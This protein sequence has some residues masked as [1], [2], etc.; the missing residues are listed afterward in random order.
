MECKLEGFI[1]CS[2][3]LCQPCALNTD[4]V[5]IDPNTPRF[6]ILHNDLKLF[7][8]IGKVVDRKE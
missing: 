4:C 3:G 6:L 1:T 5:N 2:G 8:K 7:R